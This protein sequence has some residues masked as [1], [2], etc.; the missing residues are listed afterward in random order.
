MVSFYDQLIEGIDRY[1]LVEDAE[2]E[3]CELYSV[4]YSKDSNDR[5]DLVEPRKPEVD[6][7]IE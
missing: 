6:I 2:E 1:I 5:L 3:L 4:Y 7:E